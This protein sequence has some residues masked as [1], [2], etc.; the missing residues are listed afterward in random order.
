MDDLFLGIGAAILLQTYLLGTVLYGWVQ[1]MWLAVEDGN[2][3]WILEN[4]TKIVRDWY[5]SSATY[6][7]SIV[8]LPPLAPS[9]ITS[10]NILRL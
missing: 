4:D 10:S 6:I 3:V 1:E 9:S 2:Y 7:F 8:W 5:A